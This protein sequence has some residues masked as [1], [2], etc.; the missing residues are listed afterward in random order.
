MTIENIETQ[1]LGR[2]VLQLVQNGLT[3]KAYPHDE[4][5]WTIELLGG[6]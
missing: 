6:W 1:N 3:F 4:N 5:S 2:I